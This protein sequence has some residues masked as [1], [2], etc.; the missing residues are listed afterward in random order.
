MKHPILICVV[1]VLSAALVA[2]SGSDGSVVGVVPPA[3]SAQP[4][5][6]PSHLDVTPE[7]SASG[8]DTSAQPLPSIQ[9]TPSPD[10]TP[11]PS[12]L[13]TTTVRAY[14]L[15]DGPVGSAGLVPVLREIPATKAVARAAM[16]A[17]LDGP[18]ARERGASPAISSVIPSGTELL[19]LSIKDG[20]A[21]V[22]LSGEF[23]SGGGSASQI[24]RLGQ[25]V[26]TLTQFSSVDSVAFRVDGRPVTVFGS[27]GIVLEGPV[28]RA[29]ESDPNMSMFESVLPAIFVDGPAWGAALGYGGRIW[30][31]AN[32]YEAWLSLSLYDATGRE[33]Y[34][35]QGHATCGTGC[36]GTFEKTHVYPVSEPQ[37]GTLRV[38]D[39]DE[40]GLTDGVTREYPVWLI[41][42]PPGVPEHTCG[43]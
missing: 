12:P 21:T 39:G 34:E 20:I 16:N 8:A 19:G 43:C 25:V 42:S 2:C 10:V 28:G 1:S 36:R 13:G 14:F 40:S 29:D 18:N 31:T 9:P 11:A 23:E 15:L 37:W 17:L 27:E 6:S 24:G 7:P 32:T 38:L 35:W 4:S 5:A 22:D 41:P 30:G 33:L 3:T 26:F